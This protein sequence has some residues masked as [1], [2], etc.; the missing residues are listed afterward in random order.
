MK[1][2]KG[3][4]TFAY[5]CKCVLVAFWDNIGVFKLNTYSL[6]FQK[7]NNLSENMFTKIL[8]SHTLENPH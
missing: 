5:H 2:I 4:Q 3:A 8:K 1:I 6:F 7:W